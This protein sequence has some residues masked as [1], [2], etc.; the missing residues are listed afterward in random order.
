MSL[1]FFVR[2]TVVAAVF[3]LVLG[4]I[5]P[6][7]ANASTKSN[8]ISV[9]KEQYRN[10]SSL[11][12]NERKHLFDNYTNK[13]DASDVY[14][15][16]DSRPTKDKKNIVAILIS[17]VVLLSGI[18]ALSDHA[19]KAIKH[20]RKRKIIRSQQKYSAHAAEHGR[21]GG[22]HTRTKITQKEVEEHWK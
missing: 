9:E 17:M 22:I 14:K 18:Y 19:Y 13:K 2:E 7:N 5:L 12:Q 1:N 10:N 3:T 8:E 4:I 15:Y 21:V 6:I 11:T 20:R 16:R